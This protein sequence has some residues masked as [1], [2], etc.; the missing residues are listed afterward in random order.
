MP[1]DLPAAP[2]PVSDLGDAARAAVAQ[3]CRRAGLTL[4][5]RQFEMACIAAPHVEAMTARLRHPRP[6]GEEPANVFQCP[7]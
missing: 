3:A 6:F 5:D 7:R 4:T 1:P 2:D